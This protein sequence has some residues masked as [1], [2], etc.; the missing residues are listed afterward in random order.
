MSLLQLNI[1]DFINI[2]GSDAPAPGGGSSAA[3]VGAIGI[4]LTNMVANLTLNREQYK[5]QEELMK[6]IL[7]DAKEISCSLV[8]AI[9]RDT[10]VYN[11]L[12][13]V[14]KM[15]K[16]TEEEKALRK[17]AL[18]KALKDCT[19]V[20]FEIM[21]FGLQSLKV[22]EK[23]V[24]R[25]N[26]NAISDL[27]V[28]AINLKAA[29]QGAWLNVAINIQSIKD[30]EFVEEYKTK[31]LNILEEAIPIADKIYDEVKEIIMNEK[32]N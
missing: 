18:D 28:A 23:A 11:D 6:S 30:K 4:A 19:L 20:P 3:L 31:G 9:E 10:Q 7:D 5:D 16:N 25:S 14:F 26:T 27:G 1:K 17:A 29:I 12:T 24:G 22:T 21:S 13:T 32:A 8:K 2:L 15:P